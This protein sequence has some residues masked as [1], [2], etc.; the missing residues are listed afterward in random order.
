MKHYMKA[1]FS[2]AVLAFLATASAQAGSAEKMVIALKTDDFELAKTDVS[3]LAIGESQTIETGSGTVIDILRTAD[4][5][6][7]YIDG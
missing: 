7:L 1:I 2:L 6:E 5:V 3:D 4:G